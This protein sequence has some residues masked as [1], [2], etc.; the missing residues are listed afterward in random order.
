MVYRKRYNAIPVPNKLNP[1]IGNTLGRIFI[2]E[3][4]QALH[5][6][7]CIFS[8]YEPAVA[9]I[10]QKLKNNDKPYWSA[11]KINVQPSDCT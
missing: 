3:I 9:Y 4:W 1:D 5:R 2:P 11:N 6:A 8:Y 10:T 7:A